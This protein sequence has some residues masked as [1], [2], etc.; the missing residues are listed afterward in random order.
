MKV[1]ALIETLS[2]LP[3]DA[4]VELLW[5]GATR[6]TADG[7]YLAKSGKVVIGPSGEPAYSDDDRPDGAPTKEED[8]YYRP[9]ES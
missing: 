7:A 8:P 1:K 6:S 5:D 4:D 2:E 3:Q 9:L